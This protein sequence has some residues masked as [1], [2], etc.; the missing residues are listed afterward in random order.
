MCNSIDFNIPAV[1]PLSAITVALQP[2]KTSRAHPLNVA[3]HFTPISSY[4]NPLR[5]SKKLTQQ[6]GTKN[7]YKYKDLVLDLSTMKKVGSGGFGEVYKVQ[8]EGAIAELAIKCLKDIREKKE[9]QEEARTI[10][11]LHQHNVSHVVPLIEVIEDTKYP[12]FTY[13]LVFPIVRVTLKEALKSAN[14]GYDHLGLIAFGLCETLKD[15][16]RIGYCHGDLTKRNVMLDVHC[17]ITVID[18]GSARKVPDKIDR[19]LAAPSYR[20]P[21][22]Y[23]GKHYFDASVDIWAL[24][25]LLCEMATGDI[26]FPSPYNENIETVMLLGMFVK[27]LGVPSAEYIE[28]SHFGKI[29]FSKDVNGNY[30]FVLPLPKEPDLETLKNKA[31]ER[32]KIQQKEVNELFSLI[33]NMLKWRGQDRMTPEKS[34]EWFYERFKM[35]YVPYP[36]HTPAMPS[37]P[38]SM[39]P[40][41]K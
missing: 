23:I 4:I 31:R 39:A 21:E 36:P 40:S 6:Q 13:S 37:P 19:L 16:K 14:F 5:S 11:L 3:R 35:P 10:K 20:A 15:L 2:A 12:L 7:L 24:G 17:N 29:F 9:F 30:Q 8:R 28:K 1:L 18:W 26:L 41:K 33:L 22:Y 34:Y 27:L 32:L 38:P 25:C